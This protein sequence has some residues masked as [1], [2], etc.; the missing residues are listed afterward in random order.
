MIKKKLESIE[1][2]NLNNNY[3]T[4][5]INYSIDLYL[6]LYKNT[7]KEKYL[8]LF[9]ENYILLNQILRN[10]QLKINLSYDLQNIKNGYDTIFFRKEKPIIKVIDK[11]FYN[12]VNKQQIFKDISIFNILK[13]LQKQHK[14]S[15]AKYK[16]CINRLKNGKKLQFNTLGLINTYYNTIKSKSNKTNL[17]AINRLYNQKEFVYITNYKVNL[18]QNY[19]KDLLINP[20]NFNSINQKILI[21]FNQKLKLDNTYL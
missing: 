3:N 5:K 15:K 21:E 4:G 20:M 8:N 12:Y 13:I 14:I 1:K 11:N 2:K 7:N 17:G 10:K 6:S 16:E 19:I 9:Y 18:K